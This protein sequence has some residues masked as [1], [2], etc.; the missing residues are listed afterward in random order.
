MKQRDEKKN[1]TNQILQNKIC[2]LIDATINIL[3]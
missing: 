1:E 2:Q 3:T